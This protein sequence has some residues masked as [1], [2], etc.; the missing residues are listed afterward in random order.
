RRFCGAGATCVRQVG[1]GAAASLDERAVLEVAAEEKYEQRDARKRP[2]EIRLRARQARTI[3]HRG[4]TTGA[5]RVAT[6]AAYGTPRMLGQDV[7][8][9]PAGARIELA[10]ERDLEGGA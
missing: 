1:R 3:G 5:R 10:G 9:P 8:G 6:L 4:A 7:G 2:H